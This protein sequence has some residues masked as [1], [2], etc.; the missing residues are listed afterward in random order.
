M[1]FLIILSIFI[2]LFLICR[3]LKEPL[4]TYGFHFQKFHQQLISGVL[5]A[6]IIVWFR[7]GQ[8]IK[9]ML[10]MSN[11]FI[12]Y[13]SVP[14]VLTLICELI[15]AAQEEILFRGFL[16]T[17]FQKLF[18]QPMIGLFLSAAIFGLMHYPIGRSIDQVI[19]C[20]IVGTIYGYL[21]LK[22]PKTFT[23]FSLSLTHCLCNFIVYL[24]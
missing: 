8:N 3:F 5:L 18:K 16:L 10:S 4:E 6:F 19:T 23:I 21:R 2:I 13:F 15:F 14:F 20:F 11:H 1:I 12:E 17:F 9:E 7:V 22:S 24:V